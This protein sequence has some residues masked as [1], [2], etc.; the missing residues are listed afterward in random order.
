MP[1][2]SQRRKGPKG[3]HSRLG[4]AIR[5]LNHAKDTCGIPQAQGAFGS[6]SGLL[7]VA[8]VRSPPF[9]DGEAPVHVPLG[10]HGLQSGLRRAWAVLR[11]CM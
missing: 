10:P 1:P 2:K 8:G 9:C 11:R 5:H 3:V 4:T 6:V 7:S